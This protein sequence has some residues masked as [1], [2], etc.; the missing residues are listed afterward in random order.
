MDSKYLLIGTYK[1]KP[2]S[3]GW[4]VSKRYDILW[5]KINERFRQNNDVLI[6]YFNYNSNQSIFGKIVSIDSFYF[7]DIKPFDKSLLG[8]TRDSEIFNSHR[9]DFIEGLERLVTEFKNNPNCNYKVGLQGN[10]SVGLMLNFFNNSERIRRVNL[11]SL[12]GDY[13]DLEFGQIDNKLYPIKNIQLYKVYNLTQ[14]A[15]KK[16]DLNTIFHKSWDAFLSS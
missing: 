14:P 7:F 4:Y 10:N 5:E 8:E 13:K 1:T 6:K 11:S 3:A 16:I 2:E 9:Q 15:R 12:A